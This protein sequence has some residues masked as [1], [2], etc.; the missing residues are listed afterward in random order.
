MSF[1]V[2][3]LVFVSLYLSLLVASI[4]LKTFPSD[5]SKFIQEQRNINNNNNNNK[6]IHHLYA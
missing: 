3:I 1:C 6:E 5:Q 2:G 4:L